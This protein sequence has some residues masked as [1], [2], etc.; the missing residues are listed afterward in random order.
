MAKRPTLT[1][2]GSGFFGTTQLNNNFDAIN[3]AFDN[4]LSRDGSSPNSMS[5]D[6]DMNNND[7]LNVNEA[8]FTTVTINGVNAIPTGLS[9]AP[10]A[11]DV[12]ITDTGAYY[13]SSA[14]EGALQEVGVITSGLGTMSTQNANAVAITGGTMS[15]SLITS[16]GD[17]RVAGNLVHDGDL[18]NNIQFTT[19]VQTFVTGSST[20]MD[21]SNSGVQLGG[22]GARVTTI[23]DEDTMATNSAT[24]LATQQSIKAYVDSAV[25]SVYRDTTGISPVLNTTLTWSIG[26]GACPDFWTIWAECIN[27]VSGFSVGDRFSIDVGDG[28]TAST[29]LGQSVWY[30]AGTDEMN[31][32]IGPS[33]WVYI[34]DPAGNL[35]AEDVANFKCYLHCIRFS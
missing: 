22:S 16:T 34:E 23:L 2:I 1:T 8:N 15:G 7:L 19:D 5:A 28:S 26:L 14:V 9:I 21:I 11:A 10:S 4:T 35:G 18:D 13:A 32:T 12:A 31:Y 27:A 33:A 29:N 30:N 20:R 25:G 6:I 24:A 17:I 3:T